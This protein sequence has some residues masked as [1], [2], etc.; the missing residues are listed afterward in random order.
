VADITNGIDSLTPCTASALKC[1]AAAGINFV[2]R[3]YSRTTTITGKKL[4]RTEALRISQ[5]GLQLFSI[6]EDG[7][8]AMTYFTSKRGALDAQGAVAQAQA[9]GQ[10][11]GSA[12]YFT[13]DFDAPIQEKAAR[14]ALIA[15]FRAVNENID[16]YTVGVY[17]SGAVCQAITDAQLA[18]FAWLAN[19]PKWAGFHTFT[20]WVL[21][22]AKDTTICTLNADPDQAHGDFGAWTTR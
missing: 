13:V 3:Y 21:K 9:V 2:G 1:L 8:T 14:A 18:R 7:P 17:G 16:A 10:P 11:G 19:A 22:Q 5:A 4:T 6:Y 20:S 12:I 15:Y